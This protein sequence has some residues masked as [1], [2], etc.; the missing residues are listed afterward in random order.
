MRAPQNSNHDYT[1]CALG[2]DRKQDRFGTIGGA[3]IPFEARGG[4]E[5][6]GGS[7]TEVGPGVRIRFPPAWSLVRTCGGDARPDCADV[8]AAGTAFDTSL[9][10][11][12]LLRLCPPRP[13]SR[14]LCRQRV[15]EGDGEIEPLPQ[16]L[17]VAR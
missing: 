10:R 6:Q 9:L 2:R 13:Q 14:R 16:S 7:S 3:K 17:F 4:E 12:R 5:A 8:G 1:P 15:D 11:V